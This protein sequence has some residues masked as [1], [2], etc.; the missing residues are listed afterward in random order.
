VGVRDGIEPNFDTEFKL[1]ANKNLNLNN[2]HLYNQD[3]AIQKYKDST[4]IMKEW[5]KVRLLKYYERKKFLIKKLEAR[6]EMISAKV[7]FIKE[8]VENTLDVMNKKAKVLEEELKKKGYPTLSSKIE[9]DTEEGGEQERDEPKEIVDTADYSYLTKM[10]IS[11]LTFEKK[12]ALEKEAQELEMEIKALKEKAIHTIWNEELD[13]L[14]VAWKDHKKMIEDL[15]L[16][17]D[18]DK[19]YTG[20]KP[21]KKK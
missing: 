17:N 21:T 3:G 16:A 4:E 20:K 13:K 15:L 12:T 11:Q 10:P 7:R 1:V 6:Y 14:E 5:S 9:M 8:I 18:G 2:I 19:K